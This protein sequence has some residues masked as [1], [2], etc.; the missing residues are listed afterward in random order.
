VTAALNLFAPGNDDESD[1]SS[2]SGVK[3][4]SFFSP[5]HTIHCHCRGR[6]TAVNGGPGKRKPKPRRRSGEAESRR[7]N[8]SVAQ[9]GKMD[10][11]A[12]QR[13]G[14]GTRT[15]HAQTSQAGF[16]LVSPVPPS[17]LAFTIGLRSACWPPR[18]CLVGIGDMPWNPR[19][20]SHLHK[21]A[22]CRTRAAELHQP[23]PHNQTSKPVGC[24]SSCHL[25][26]L[27]LHAAFAPC[28]AWRRDGTHHVRGVRK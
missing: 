17:H 15:Q 8:E 7:E 21:Q 3:Q 19:K 26:Q 24:D 25:P 16:R 6:S 2:L 23:P 5:L 18:L 1:V 14:F 4:A 10:A 12:D 28:T 22:G 20:N 13:Q 9:V 27:P 11:V